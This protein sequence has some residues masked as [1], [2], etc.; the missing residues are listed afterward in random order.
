[1]TN[2]LDLLLRTAGTLL[3]VL[4]LYVAFFLYENEEGRLQNTL[5][6]LWIR[7]ADRSD[8]GSIAISRLAGEVSRLTSRALDR[9]FG[10]QYLSRRAIGVSFLKY[11]YSYS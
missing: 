6:E 11:S 10:Q 9:I 8:G 4:S 3:G 7:V 1:M 2:V 5:E